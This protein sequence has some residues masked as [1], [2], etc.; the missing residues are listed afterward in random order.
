MRAK[1]PVAVIIPAYNEAEAIGKVIAEIPAWVDQIVVADNG[2]TD[3]TASVARNAGAEVVHEPRRGYGYACMAGLTKVKGATII[4]FLDGDHSDFPGMMDR[5]VDPIV[6]GRADLVIGSRTL[7]TASAGSLSP[8]QRFGNAL[9]CFLIRL[10][11]RHAYTDLGPFRAVERT[12]FEEMSLVEMTY[13]WTVEMQIR[14]LE[15]RLRCLDVPVNYRCR[16][17]RS[18]V[19]GTVQGVIGAGWRILFCIF[20]S[21]LKAG[22]FRREA[23]IG[24][25]KPKITRIS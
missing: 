21:A 17:G 2:S 6:D 10:I 8:Q 15:L 11:W 4:V 3:Q 23:P 7:G 14:A 19:S 1:W 9:A 24:T 13:G 12:A 18:K 16:I 25:Q 5:I 20:R 22:A